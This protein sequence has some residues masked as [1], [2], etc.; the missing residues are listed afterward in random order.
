VSND[1][2]DTNSADNTNATSKDIQIRQHI[3]GRR[4]SFTSFRQLAILI[5]FPAFACRVS[6]ITHRIDIMTTAIT[7]SVALVLHTI[8]G[9][10]HRRNI[11]V[12]T[13]TL[14]SGTSGVKATLYE[15]RTG[16][17]KVSSTFYTE[18]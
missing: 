12:G 18:C 9:V 6:N 1:N 15:D 13:L 14:S 7:I 17:T 10:V 5:I 8:D 3:I 11:A 4:D 16:I 2:E